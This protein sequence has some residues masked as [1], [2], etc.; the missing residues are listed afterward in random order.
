MA[1]RK[2]IFV[3]QQDG[4]KTYWHRA[5]IGFVNRDGSINLRLDLFP[6]LQLQLREPREDSDRAKREN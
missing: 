3:I 4:D 2:E 5:G 1:Q 6:N